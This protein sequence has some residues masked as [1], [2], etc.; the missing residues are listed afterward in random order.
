MAG[1]K[2]LCRDEDDTPF[3]A[4]YLVSFGTDQRSKKFLRVVRYANVC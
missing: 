1:L 3:L 2:S 4:R